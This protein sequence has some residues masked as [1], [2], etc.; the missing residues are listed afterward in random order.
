MN[1]T[2]TVQSTHSYKEGQGLCFSCASVSQ[3][4]TYKLQCCC[5]S[6]INQWRDQ[7]KPSQI[8][9]R[10]AKVRDIPPPRIEGDST[11]LSLSGKLYNLQD[12]GTANLKSLI[13][14]FLVVFLLISTITVTIS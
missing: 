12:F 8:L 11:S 5:S 14:I 2:S 10:V 3:S 6:G 7:L 1:A 9:Q 4:Q 13:L